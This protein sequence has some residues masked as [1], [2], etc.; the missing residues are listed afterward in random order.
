[1]LFTLAQV[2]GVLTAVRDVPEAQM[3]LRAALE[4]VLV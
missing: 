3:K 1:M 2:I 4:I